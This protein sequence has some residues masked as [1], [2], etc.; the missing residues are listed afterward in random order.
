MIDINKTMQPIKLVRSIG[1]WQIKKIQPAQD[2]QIQLGPKIEHLKKC[3]Y[4][5]NKFMLVIIH[6]VPKKGPQKLASNY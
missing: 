4:R 6:N 3:I 5:T 1:F 2:Q